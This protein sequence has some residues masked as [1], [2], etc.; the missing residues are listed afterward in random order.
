MFSPQRIGMC[1]GACTLVFLSSNL[2]AGA[3]AAQLRSIFDSARNICILFQTRDFLLEI[4]Q[5]AIQ[6]WRY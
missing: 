2:S 3:E 1:T 6:V 4:E 5:L